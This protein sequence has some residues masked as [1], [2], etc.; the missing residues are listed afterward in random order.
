MFIHSNPASGCCQAFPT[1]RLPS[2]EAHARAEMV[3]LPLISRS[4]GI[5]SFSP[6]R[7]KKAFRLGENPRVVGISLRY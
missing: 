3:V 4:F 2:G 7:V 6:S 5:P 1:P